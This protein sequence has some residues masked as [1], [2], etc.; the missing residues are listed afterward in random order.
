MCQVQESPVRSARDVDLGVFED[1]LSFYIRSVGIACSRDLDA[2]LDGYEVAKGTG[3]ISLLLLVDSH[4]GIRPSI[5]A[6]LTLKD[7]SAI[8]RLIATME[9]QG[10]LT[11]EVSPDD[12]RAQS[13]TITDKG[14]AL[15][16]RVRALVKEQ[17]EDFFSFIPAEERVQLMEILKRAYRRIAG[18]A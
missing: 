11:R 18:L 1:L 4:P 12:S 3:K 15:A 16:A 8:A 10:L 5:I 13:L 9:G 7:R 14:H 17:S 6:D 2:R